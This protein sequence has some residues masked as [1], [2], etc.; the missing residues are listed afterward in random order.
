MFVGKLEWVNTDQTEEKPYSWNNFAVSSNQY[1]K[2]SRCT[3]AL[4]SN[5]LP[6]GFG[7][8]GKWSKAHDEHKIRIFRNI[9]LFANY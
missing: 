1:D 5:N 7:Q 8:E 9:E 3:F 6:Q 2:A 4:F